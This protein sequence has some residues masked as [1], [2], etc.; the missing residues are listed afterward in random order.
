[1]GSEKIR[2]GKMD[3]EEIVNIIKEN[4]LN[5]EYIHIKACS[6]ASGDC[7]KWFCRVYKDDL[8][9]E[10]RYRPGHGLIWLQIFKKEK[11]LIFFGWKSKAFIRQ[12]GHTYNDTDFTMNLVDWDKIRYTIMNELR[13]RKEQETRKISEMVK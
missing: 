10:L 1:M 8:C 9:F 11:G 4:I 5:A 13:E 2:N 6:W 7:Q 12:S 3:K